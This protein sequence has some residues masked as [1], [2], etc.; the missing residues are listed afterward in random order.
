MLLTPAP[1]TSMFM[2]IIYSKSTCVKIS[3]EYFNNVRSL[4]NQLISLNENEGIS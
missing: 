4:K 1:S 2:M 3:T